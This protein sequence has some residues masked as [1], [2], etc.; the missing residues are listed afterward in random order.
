VNLGL[1]DCNAFYC[2][3]ERLFQ[4]LLK[5]KPVVVL[6]NNDGCAVSR[7]EEAK[8]LGVKMGEPYFKFK[9]L[10]QSHDLKVF[11]SNFSLYTDLSWR[12]MEWLRAYAPS[13]EVYSIDEAFLDVTGITE[14]V[15]FGQRLRQELLRQVGIPV[16]IGF[17]PTK[18]LAKAANR[19][20]KK[21][22]KSQ[23][24]VDLTQTK[25]H[26]AGLSRLPIEDVWGIGRAQSQKMRLLG[27]KTAWDLREYKNEK[28]IEK[29]F[30]KIGWQI[31][32]ELR[33]ERCFPFQKPAEAKKEIMCSRTFGTSV[34]DK[35]A[36]KE[37]VAH[38]V[39]SAAEKL[40]QQ[41]SVCQEVTVFARTNPFRQELPQYT[42]YETRR[43]PHPTL[44]T[45]K[46]ITVAQQLVDQGYREGYEYKKAGVRLSDFY[47]ST[48]LQLDFL[49]PTDTP[50]RHELMKV[51]DR[52]HQK[53]GK[54]ILKSAACGVKDK[55]WRMNRQHKSPRY[56]TDWN[57]LKV[58]Y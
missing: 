27:I 18:V 54:G 30:T 52:Y 17:G 36:L 43:L 47:Q 46:L 32:Q 56:T 55:A 58:F 45:F 42:F 35:V 1:V 48:E 37:A 26:Q 38:Y 41:G 25:W 34:E 24:V 49:T 9:H 39:T 4:P 44:D 15:V 2:S 7:S 51:I 5:T 12:V 20:A 21:S 40:R 33:G 14:L 16:G 8:A 3:C 53:E 11:S 29:I 22:L 31:Q 57:E 50:E 13:I 28:L 10:C 19:L 23:G 6:S